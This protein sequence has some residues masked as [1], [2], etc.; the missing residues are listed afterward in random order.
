VIRPPERRTRLWLVL[1]VCGAACASAP[2][3]P[4]DRGELALARGHPAAAEAAF[5][6]ALAE[7]PDDLRAL[8]GLA[9]AQLGQDRP[10]PALATLDRLE[11]IDPGYAHVAAGRDHARALARAA[12]ARL[13]ARPPDPD[14][15]LARLDR[16]DALHPGAVDDRGLRARALSLQAERARAR[17]DVDAAV[18]RYRAAVAAD[19]THLEAALALADLLLEQGRTDEAVSL[20]TDALRR[21]PE[22]LRVQRLMVD[23]LARP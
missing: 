5:R 15:A 17:G 20:L 8:H 12:E 18:G 22:D 23:A 13:R 19:P 1:L 11:A 16:L 21:H 2:H 9:R 3:H 4:V 6:E 10:E 14:G 7:R